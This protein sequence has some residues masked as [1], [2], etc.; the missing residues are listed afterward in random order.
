MILVLVGTVVPGCGGCC[1]VLLSA[2]STRERRSMLSIGAVP[3]GT[4]GLN[5]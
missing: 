5:S 3:A 4:G 2:E 1:Q